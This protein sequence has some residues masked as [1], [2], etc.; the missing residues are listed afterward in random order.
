MYIMSR[1]LCLRLIEIRFCLKSTF[2]ILATIRG[3]PKLLFSN[4]ETLL[5]SLRP[6]VS[7]DEAVRTTLNLSCEV[8]F[9]VGSSISAAIVLRKFFA[10]ST[11][12]FCLHV[13]IRF[14]LCSSSN[15]NCRWCSL[16]KLSCFVPRGFLDF[17]RHRFLFFRSKLPFGHPLRIIC[18]IY[19]CVQLERYTD[20]L[21]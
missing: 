13:I 12:K 16:G 6:P 3:G 14:S 7:Q 19:V 10:I 15:F 2:T 18:D 21:K 11:L 1:Y 8:R 5:P 20:L 4:L 17:I 9:C